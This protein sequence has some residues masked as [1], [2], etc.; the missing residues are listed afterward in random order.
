MAHPLEGAG[1][2]CVTSSGGVRGASREPLDWQT[3]SDD[4]L[5]NRA[6]R[7]ASDVIEG[8]ARERRR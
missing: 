7:M 1:P 6:T 3:L 5:P 4:S 8:L 2:A